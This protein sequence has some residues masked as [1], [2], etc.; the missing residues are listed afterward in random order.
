MFIVYRFSFQ[1]QPNGQILRV[2]HPPDDD[3]VLATK[4]GLAAMLSSKLHHKDEAS[5]VSTN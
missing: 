5:Y 3:E 4:K 2:Y 1:I